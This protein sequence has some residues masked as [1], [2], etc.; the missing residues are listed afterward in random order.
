[1]CCITIANYRNYKNLI[2]YRGRFQ[3][4]ASTTNALRPGLSNTTITI[5]V[6]EREKG[7]AAV[8]TDAPQPRGLLRNPVMKMSR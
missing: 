5:F 7:T 8:A 1:L 3:A 6:E 2:K 4:V